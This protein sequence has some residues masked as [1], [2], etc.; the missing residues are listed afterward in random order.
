[1][2]AAI[3]GRYI[4][5]C[6]RPWIRIAASETVEISSRHAHRARAQSC[7]KFREGG[8][9]RPSP[10]RDRRRRCHRG[11]VSGRRRRAARGR[12]F[13]TGFLSGDV[14]LGKHSIRRQRRAVRNVLVLGFFFWHSRANS[15]AARGSSRVAH[16]FKVESNMSNL[17]CPSDVDKAH[18]LAELNS[19]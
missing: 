7:A 2:R 19:L 8:D 15:A 5:T 16:R 6:V 13:E 14:F 4:M 18:C 3:H 1:M 9:V 17:A 12:D 11:A 10:S